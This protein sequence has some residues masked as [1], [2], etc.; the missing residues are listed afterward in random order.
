M[1]NYMSSGDTVTANAP[2]ALTSGEG[3][4]IGAMFGVAKAA[5]ANGAEGE[6]Q[7]V[8]EVELTTLGTDTAAVGALAYWDNTNFRVTTTASGNTKIG[9][10]TLAKASGPTVGRVRLNGAF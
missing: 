5:Y 9:V 3:A 6:F 8:G 1:K 4:L 10:F 7:M 2:R